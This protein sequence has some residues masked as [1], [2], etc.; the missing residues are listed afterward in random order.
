[1]SFIEILLLAASLSL[2]AAIVSVGAGALTKVTPRRALLL[3]AVFGGFH[4]FMPLLGWLGGSLFREALMAYGN[5]IGFVLLLLVGLKML[6]EA[7]GKE[8]TDAERNAFHPGTM[9]LLAV[10]TSIDVFVVGITFSFIEAPVALAITVIALVTFAA[11]LVGIYM[12]ARSKHVLGT[13]VEI[14]GALVLILLAFKV[15][16]F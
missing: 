13:K 12:G 5:V 2:D 7:L 14:V 4:A 16:L 10:A 1:M 15:L 3:A 9:L 6:K 11:S 8:D